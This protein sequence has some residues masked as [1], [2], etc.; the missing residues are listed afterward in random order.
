MGTELYVFTYEETYRDLLLNLER[1][2]EEVKEYERKR[3]INAPLTIEEK[4]LSKKEG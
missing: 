1:A 3:Y 4:I 2:L